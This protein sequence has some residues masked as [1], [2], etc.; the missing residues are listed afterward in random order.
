MTD[1]FGEILHVLKDVA[2]Q[3]DLFKRGILSLENFYVW[4]TELDTKIDNLVNKHLEGRG[5][6]DVA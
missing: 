5:I 3:H 1:N 4:A 2:V 6:G